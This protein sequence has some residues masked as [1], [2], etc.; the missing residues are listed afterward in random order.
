MNIHE[1]PLAR[2]YSNRIIGL[3]DGEVVFDGAPS[4]LD[5][6]ATDQIYRGDTDEIAADDVSGDSSAT[7]T[8]RNRTESTVRAMT[9]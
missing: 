1:V 7:D 6:T 9:R 4:E 8:D 5:E 3:H 2:E